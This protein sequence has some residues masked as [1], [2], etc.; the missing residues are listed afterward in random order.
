[1]TQTLVCSS[2]TGVLYNATI[3]PCPLTM[4]IVNIGQTE[5]KVES[6]FSEVVQLREDALFAEEMGIGSLMGVGDD[7]DEHY[8]AGEQEDGAAGRKESGAGAKK[9][10]KGGG[11]GGGARKSAATAA[12]KPRGGGVKKTTGAAKG[13]GRAKK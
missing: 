11:G 5:A 1:M 6:F 7:E 3:V 4:A 2:C 8:G 13:K 12:K 9:K 10:K